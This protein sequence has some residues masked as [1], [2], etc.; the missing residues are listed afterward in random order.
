MHPLSGYPLNLLNF[1]DS[2][3]ELILSYKE[4]IN[5][6][7]SGIGLSP[8][9]VDN[10]EKEIFKAK[11]SE[12]HRLP[13]LRSF[14]IEM[15]LVHPKVE[16]SQEYRQGMKILELV[17]LYEQKASEISLKIEKDLKTK[18][19]EL[20]KSLN[21]FAN[22]T[23]DNYKKKKVSLPTGD[24]LGYSDFKEIIQLGLSTYENLGDLI[25]FNDEYQN[26]INNFFRTIKQQVLS[27]KCDLNKIIKSQNSQIINIELLKENDPIAYE[28]LRAEAFQIF[29][30]GYKIP[31]N[32]DK[33]RIKLLAQPSTN[34][35]KNLKLKPSEV[36]VFVAS[37]DPIE[38]WDLNTGDV[39]QGAFFGE[40]GVTGKQTTDKEEIKVFYETVDQKTLLLIPV[41]F[42]YLKADLNYKNLL[43]K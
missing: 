20:I 1:K 38:K 41:Y 7:L 32:S 18:I 37:V 30:E 5:E 26:S 11:V 8:L 2:E 24:Y 13:E 25:L 31:L 6:I 34:V 29:C 9:P 40:F 36:A 43:K 27:Q 10:I 23:R 39:L 17:P 19:S 12:L 35:G 28:Y 4:K 42:S 15:S 22:N 3:K 14:L 16:L 33:N 21:N